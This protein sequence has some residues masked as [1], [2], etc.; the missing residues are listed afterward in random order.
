MPS[1]DM[2]G[3]KAELYKAEIEGTEMNVCSECG[4]FGKIIKKLQ[5][6][7]PEPKKKKESF[8]IKHT[9]DKEIIQVIVPNY[10]KKIK[11]RREELGLKQEELAKKISE[12]L[13]LVH[14]IESGEFEPNINLARKLEK[15][16]KIKLVKQQEVSKDIHFKISPDQL[17]VGDFIKVKR[18]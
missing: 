13:S 8:I 17:T 6:P 14:H 5:E 10:S 11:Q 7:K 3:K 4:K 1:C 2:C 18:K 12:K 16:L 9:S 15:F